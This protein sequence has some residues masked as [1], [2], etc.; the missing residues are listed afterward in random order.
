MNKNWEE[1]MNEFMEETAGQF[2]SVSFRKASKLIIKKQTH[3]H[4]WIRG[5]NS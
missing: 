1:G 2:F 4:K 5:V 3:N